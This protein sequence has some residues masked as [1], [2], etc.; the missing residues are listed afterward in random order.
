MQ[1][2]GGDSS[3]YHELLGWRPTGE[4]FTVD[5]QVVAGRSA[6][7]AARWDVHAVVEDV[8]AA[9]AAATRLGGAVLSAEGDTAVLADPA[10]ARFVVRSDGRRAEILHRPSAFSWAELCTDD[11][12]GAK[13]F[14]CG[15]FGWSTVD[16][17]LAMPA[18]EVDYP[19]FL[20]GEAEAAGLL[21][22]GGAFGPV[23]PRYWLCYVEVRDAELVA[24]QVI[25]LGGA[26][27]AELFDVPKIGRIGLFAGRTGELFAVMQMP[28]G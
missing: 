15:L 7:G 13:A 5:G 4:V 18:G 19:V 21:P 10:G 9:C 27:L 11:V 8:P 22:A 24:A 17:V 6:G 26:V 16:G 3:F 2:T 12:P 25:A 14:Y 28:T 20:A 1:L 23:P